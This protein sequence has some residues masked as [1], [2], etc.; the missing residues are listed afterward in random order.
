MAC[1]KENEARERRIEMEAVVDAYNSE[2]RAMGWY[3]YLEERLK[4]PFKARCTSKREISPLRVGENV[5]VTGM[6]REEECESEMFVR[7]LW[8]GR[9]LAVPLSQLEPR[10]VDATTREAVGDW[11]Y[12]VS[13]GYKF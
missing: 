4:F 5:D 1:L 7:V 8:C 13:R 10:G 11:H 2:E 9:R 3:Y 6:A 12:W